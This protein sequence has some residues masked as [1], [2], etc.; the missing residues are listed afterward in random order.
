[1]KEFPR[2]LVGSRMDVVIIMDS[3]IINRG[4]GP[5]IRGT[6]ITV[7]DVLD[8]LE[9]GWHHTRIAAF[10]R[11]SS[12]EVLAALQYIDEHKS[13]VMAEY[14]QILARDAQGNPPELQARLDADHEKFLEMM[15]QRKQRIGPA[16]TH[17]GNSGGQ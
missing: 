2:T 16:V 7:Y 10:F 1:M 4:R 3:I 11:I 17:A 12:Q 14:Q 9:I 8:Y 5:E 13:E 15:R 6:R